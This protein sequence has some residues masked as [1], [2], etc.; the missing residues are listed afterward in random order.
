MS[1]CSRGNRLTNNDAY[2]II[3]K[4]SIGQSETIPIAIL[5]KEGVSMN[6]S[7]REEIR[8]VITVA[9]LVM[10]LFMLVLTLGVSYTGG[11]SI[12]WSESLILGALTGIPV[13]VAFFLSVGRESVGGLPVAIIAAIGFSLTDTIMLQF[14]FGWALL[15]MFLTGVLAIGIQLICNKI[16]ETVRR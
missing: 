12:S 3:S 1:I 7:V 10:S 8:K 16:D 5:R 2:A 6:T 13:S 14:G 9:C 15:A 4:Y 11:G